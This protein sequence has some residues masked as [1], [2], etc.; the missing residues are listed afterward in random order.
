MLFRSVMRA[1]STDG[2]NWRKYGQKQVKSPT[3]SRS[4]YRCTHSECCAKKIECSDHSG[5]VVEV[6]Y[7]SQHSHD[8]PRKTNYGRESKFASS[9]QPNVENIV[10]EKPIRA[11]NDL[12]PCPSSNP[13]SKQ[14]PEEVPCSADGK[15]QN[16]SDQRDSGRDDLKDE[17]IIE[18]ESKKRQVDAFICYF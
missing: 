6:V 5:H 15:G 8:P 17:H 11:S 4:Y 2:Y 18:T 1:S 14:P 13:S 7:K 10:L 3:G 16:S 9:K 12:N